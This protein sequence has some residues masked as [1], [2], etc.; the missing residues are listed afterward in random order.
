MSIKPPFRWI[1]REINNMRQHQRKAKEIATYTGETTE[2]VREVIGHQ[3][4]YF[5]PGMGHMF[6]G[7]V[8]ILAGETARCPKCGVSQSVYIPGHPCR[9]CDDV[10]LR[11]RGKAPGYGPQ[12][13]HKSQEHI[14]SEAA[15]L[16]LLRREPSPI[17]ESVLL[18]QVKG[19]GKIELEE[20]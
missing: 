9:L 10:I 3:R 4:S 7:E 11:S 19:H 2:T 5:G 15:A 16:R 1:Q 12:P 17:R 14:R 18:K 6:Y 8:S 20:Q 13:D